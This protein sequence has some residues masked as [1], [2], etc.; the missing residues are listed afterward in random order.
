METWAK[1]QFSGILLGLCKTI[2]RGDGRGF[3]NPGNDSDSV[4]IL[5]AR[6]R[7]SIGKQ[8]RAESMK[9]M[10]MVKIHVWRSTLMRLVEGAL[11]RKLMFF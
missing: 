10:T 6:T 7:R 1:I 11:R 8:L 3:F 9:E 4:E 2:S 5:R